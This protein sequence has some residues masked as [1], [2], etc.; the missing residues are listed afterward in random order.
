MSLENRLLFQL[1][2][3]TL[4][5]NIK[6]RN[7]HKG[8]SCY[9][10]GNGISLK[11]MDFRKFDDKVSIGCGYLF[12]H[13]D[14]DA[15]NMKYYT[16][17]EPFWFY[18][19][20]KSRGTGR[21]ERNRNSALQKRILK[22]Y[23]DINFFTSLSNRFAIA[24]DRIYYLHHFD[25]PE[26]GSKT[27]DMAGMFFF[28][29]ALHVMIGMAIYMGFEKAYLVGCDYTHSP[30]R[31]LHFYEKGKGK[32]QY[33]DDHNTDFFKVAREFIDLVTVTTNGATSKTLD[34]VDYRDYTGVDPMFRENTELVKK[35]YLDVL[36]DF[37]DYSV[38]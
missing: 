33:N 8:E 6:F 5:R 25:V 13:N 3:R 1:S 38:Y 15:L 14:F 27:F 23:P 11:D 32:I 22:E 26:A 36:A 17:I 18:P 9:I 2:K 35:E 16:E 19:F 28:R 31:I 12:L 10:F 21:I 20:W 4:K 34:Y 24:G 37:Y 30:Q 7:I 29:G